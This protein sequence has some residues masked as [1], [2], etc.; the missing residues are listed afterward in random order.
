[1]SDYI[2]RT[3][4]HD[5]MIKAWT[6]FMPMDFDIEG[7]FITATINAIPSIDIVRCEECRYLQGSTK[8][9]WGDCDYFRKRLKH[10]GGC[11]FGEPQ[12]DWEKELF[13]DEQTERSE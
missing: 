4:A 12:I 9:E 3:D 11:T 1:M 10:S 13:D 6:K 7:S 2:K 8:Y 5:M